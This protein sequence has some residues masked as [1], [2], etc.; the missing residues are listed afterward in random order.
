MKAEPTSAGQPL[1]ISIQVRHCA[2]KEQK[3][4]K[5]RSQLPWLC[6][7]CTEERDGIYCFVL[8]LFESSDCSGGKSMLSLLC[9][10]C[11]RVT[12]GLR[13]PELTVK[14]DGA[15]CGVG[16]L[17]CFPCSLDAVRSPPCR[18]NSLLLP[19]SLCL[20]SKQTRCHGF[21]RMRMG[22]WGV[23]IVR[24]SVTSHY[25]TWLEKNDP[26]V[27][28]T[29]RSPCSQGQ[30]WEWVLTWNR[31]E[32]PHRASGM[33]VKHPHARLLLS[34]WLI[35]WCSLTCRNKVP[36]RIKMWWVHFTFTSSGPAKMSYWFAQQY[37]W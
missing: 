26:I 27:P 33:T 9:S 28:H 1:L 31:K 34:Y 25:T 15:W 23:S 30:S 12:W 7:Q 6:R 32:F 11:G 18:C 21:T 5:K 13:F 36:K 16:W 24:I 17:F 2:M 3:K 29:K 10:I 35:S 4:K 19:L 8:V 37:Q 22:M 20:R 14:P